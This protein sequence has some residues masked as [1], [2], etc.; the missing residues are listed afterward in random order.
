MNS[1]IVHL[2]CSSTAISQIEEG[3]AKV[4]ERLGMPPQS[5]MD[6]TAMRLTQIM[7][8]GYHD[9]MSVALKEQGLNPTSWMTLMMFF[10][11]EGEPLNPSDLATITG[12]SR[13]NMTRICD[14]LVAQGYITRFPSAQ[15]RRRVDLK[16]SDAGAELI[17]R[18]APKLREHLKPVRESITEEEKQTLIRI[19]KKQ[20]LALP[21]M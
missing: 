12:E 1:K 7:A 19:L 15:D 4:A 17:R 11:A 6:I 16:L 10:K 9:V 14:E 18:T 5:V 13:T 21:D 20:L 3:V 8:R 2:S